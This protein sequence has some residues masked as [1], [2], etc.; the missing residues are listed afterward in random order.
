MRLCARICLVAFLLASLVPVAVRAESG[1]PVPV[2]VGS[3]PGYGRVVFDLPDR[4]DYRLTQQGQRVLVRFTGDV[5]IGSAPSMP[6]N[7]V[8][9]TGGAG[10]AELVVETGT[11]VHAWRLGNLV[12]VDVLD[13]AL[14]AGGP[15]ASVQASVPTQ[16]SGAADGAAPSTS[17]AAAA[18]PPASVVVP[19]PSAVPAKQG[20]KAAAP[21]AL[22]AVHSASPA[23]NRV[24]VRRN[25]RRCSRR[26]LGKKRRGSD[27]HG[28]S[29]AIR[30]SRETGAESSST[31]SGGATASCFSGAVIATIRSGWRSGS[32]CIRG[33]GRRACGIRRCSGATRCEGGSTA[34]RFGGEAR[35]YGCGG[36]IS[37][38]SRATR[39]TLRG[40]DGPDICPAI[41][42][43]ICSAGQ[44]DC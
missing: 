10:Q 18:V 6:H 3:H 12:V 8:G 1:P 31:T 29:V 24:A 13:E 19:A 21:Q 22:A 33:Q 35:R 7:V 28:C 39:R 17:V 38:G 16:P 26:I 5:T 14:A 4:L 20:P 44:P 11:V 34:T 36:Q 25:G 40:A 15:P 41:A 9:L 43:G 2:R 23:Q 42:T 27:C 30:S 32:C 37:A